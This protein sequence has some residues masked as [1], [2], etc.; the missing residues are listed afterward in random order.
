MVTW[1]AG[2]ERSLFFKWSQ[3]V[4][5]FIFKTCV[6]GKCTSPA[7]ASPLNTDV[8]I[9]YL[10]TMV[11]NY[12]LFQVWHEW[13]CC[14]VWQVGAV[15]SQASVEGAALAAATAKGC[16]LLLLLRTVSSVTGQ[17]EVFSRGPV[18]VKPRGP[19]WPLHRRHA[20][21]HPHWLISVPVFLSPGVEKQTGA[22]LIPRAFEA[23][24]RARGDTG[25]CEFYGGT[26][27]GRDVPFFY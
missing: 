1:R 23:P 24:W 20:S 17:C 16:F 9:F 8:H 3:Y 27:A 14:L 5:V 4:E 25:P 12:A 15:L 18:A 11:W 6:R 22:L 7:V 2:I 19:L 10:T 26:L 21:P 13:G